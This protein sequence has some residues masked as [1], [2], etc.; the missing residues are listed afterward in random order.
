MIKKECG[1]PKERVAEWRF[2]CPSCGGALTDEEHEAWCE[3][4]YPQ[5]RMKI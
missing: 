4:H 2:V 3:S 5:P 1:E